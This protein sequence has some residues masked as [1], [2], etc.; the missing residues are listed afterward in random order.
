M[1]SFRSPLSSPRSWSHFGPDT[2]YEDRALDCEGAAGAHEGFDLLGRRFKCCRSATVGVRV[3]RG[4]ALRRGGS[5][6]MIDVGMRDRM[7]GLSV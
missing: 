5:A 7:V 2:R 1:S 6:A 3:S 4:P